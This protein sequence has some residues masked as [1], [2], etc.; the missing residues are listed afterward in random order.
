MTHAITLRFKQHKDNRPR[1]F[2]QVV[3]WEGNRCRNT[4]FSVGAHGLVGAV[5]RCY[6][7]RERVGA[8]L[9]RIARP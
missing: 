9:D 7:A 8:A 4:S 1:L 6:L 3:W 5:Q 2:A